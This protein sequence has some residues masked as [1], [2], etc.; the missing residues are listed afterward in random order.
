MKIAELY[1][2]LPSRRLIPY[3]FTGKRAPEEI[4]TE[5]SKVL[6]RGVGAM[7]RLCKFSPW[8]AG[9]KM[10]LADIYVYYVNTIVNTFSASQL[11][12]DILAEIPG[13]KAWTA[14]MSESAIAQRVEADRVANMPDFM[15]YIKA[16]QPAPKA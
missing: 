2:E 5:I 4:Q 8:I 13:M 14:A 16:L 11:N 9:D 3:A 15:A 1:L 10:T 7:A 12:R 6:N